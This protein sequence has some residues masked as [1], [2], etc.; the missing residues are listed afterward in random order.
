MKKTI[1]LLFSIVLLTFYG[2]IPSLHPIYTPESRIINDDII[3]TWVLNET[4]EGLDISFSFQSDEEQ[5][6]KEGK[7]M[8]DKLSNEL[9]NRNS[10]WTFERA[11]HITFNKIGEKSSRITINPGAPSFKPEGFEVSKKELLPYYIL[12]YKEKIAGDTI[13]HYMVVNLTK[14]GTNTYMDF[15]P[16]HLK[17]K[18]L[19]GRFSTNYINGHTFAQVKIQAQKLSIKAFDIEFIED[20]I[21]KKRLR[22]K[23]EKLSN[24][25]I[26]LTASTK[27]LRSFIE[28]YGNDEELYDGVE[29]LQLMSE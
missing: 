24:D 28:K 1:V 22:L 19:Q 20:L 9:S 10:I 17:D 6:K 29:E 14:I 25:Q 23:H 4:I 2:C 15:L 8:M 12:T 18:K 7:L 27:E 16:Y 26:I 3:N 5:D 13:T 11:A 21:R